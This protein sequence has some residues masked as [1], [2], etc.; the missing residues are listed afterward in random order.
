L[1]SFRGLI[2]H[3]LHLGHL[4]LGQHTAQRLEELHDLLR[5]RR[6]PRPRRRRRYRRRRRRRGVIWALAV[7]GGSVRLPL[8]RR[9]VGGAAGGRGCHLYGHVVA[10][11]RR[12]PAGRR[13]ERRLCLQLLGALLLRRQQILLL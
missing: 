13:R 11:R 8:L 1:Q 9:R 7:S 3:L 4:L 5:R 12:D 6:L 10:Q 2:P